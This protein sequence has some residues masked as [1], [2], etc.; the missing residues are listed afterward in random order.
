M[1]EEADG[2]A[3]VFVAESD[4]MQSRGVSEGDAPGLVDF[5]VSDS[6]VPVA[7]VGCGL[8]SGGVGVGGG[9]VVEDLWGRS[10]L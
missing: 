6:P 7:A 2:G 10:W 9:A 1:D 5:V 4:V 8:G 3:D